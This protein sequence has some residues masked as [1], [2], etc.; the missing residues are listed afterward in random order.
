MT[1][2]TPSHLLLTYRL[3]DAN[4]CNFHYFKYEDFNELVKVRKEIHKKVY[5]YGIKV[6]FNEENKTHVSD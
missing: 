5:N 2:K 6:L 1:P 3:Y 4:H